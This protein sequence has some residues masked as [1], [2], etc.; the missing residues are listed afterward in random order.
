MF[1][2]Q[3]E[4]CVGS[5]SIP[6]FPIVDS[7]ANVLAG[8][9]GGGVWRGGGGG[10]GAM[11]RT[12]LKGGVG[13]KGVW[14]PKICAPKMV[15]P[16]FPPCQFRVF[17]TMATFV[18]GGGGR[19]HPSP[20]KKTIKHRPGYGVGGRMRERKSLCRLLHVGLHDMHTSHGITH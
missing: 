12:V 18:W 3:V 11:G 14:D 2:S 16:D 13:G 19:G 9:F 17:P 4:L 5:G 8:G 1:W 6:Q 10:G 15:R 20:P 7:N